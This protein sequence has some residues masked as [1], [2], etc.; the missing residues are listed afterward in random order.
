MR[1]KIIPFIAGILVGGTSASAFTPPSMVIDDPV[2][3]LAYHPAKIHYEAV[4]AD[5]V[6]RC[7]DLREVGDKESW[8]YAHVRV[9]KA[10][11]YIINGWHPSQD[12]DSLGNAFRLEGAKCEG[13]EAGNMFTGYVPPHGYGG[14]T[15]TSHLPGIDAP[16]VPDEGRPGD[17]H[18]MLRSPGEEAVI[19]GL[20][21]DAEQRGEKAWG[22]A[23]FRKQVCSAPAN[24][25]AP[26]LNE[27]TRIYCSRSK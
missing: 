6:R 2:F 11:Y 20:I 1:L 16:D 18:Y 14:H 5:L 15:E 26:I 25:F 22:V 13:E 19:R 12:G 21:R 3:G 4:P 24:T 23:A 8:I 27:E 7:K 9:D 10:D 17:Y